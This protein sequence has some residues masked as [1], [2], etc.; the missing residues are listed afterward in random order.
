MKG[1]IK[2]EDLTGGGGKRVVVEK[3][4]IKKNRQVL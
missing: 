3:K 4:S 2:K 1:K